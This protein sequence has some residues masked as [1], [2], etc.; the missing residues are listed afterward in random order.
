[1]VV[2]EVVVSDVVEEVD[3]VF[4]GDIVVVDVD[5]DDDVVAVVVGIEVVVDIDVVVE[6]DVDIVVFAEDVV[7][8]EFV[9]VEDVMELFDS[10]VVGRTVVWVDDVDGHVWPVGHIVVDVEVVELVVEDVVVEVEDTVGIEMVE[11]IDVDMLIVVAFAV[12]VDVDVEDVDEVDDVDG[13]V[14]PVGQI[15]VDEDVV[16]LLKLVDED[17]D[18][19]EDDVVVVL[20][21]LHTGEPIVVGANIGHIM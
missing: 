6:I 15:V 10:D 5:V 12:V 7:V 8:D 16:E 1:V 19:V 18:D 17:V 21:I 14:W 4:V 2:N 13:H 11:G 3:V 9:D 20:T